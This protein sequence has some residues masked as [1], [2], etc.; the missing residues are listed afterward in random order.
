VGQR[1]NVG[2]GIWIK[3]DF[4]KVRK[5]YD[6]FGVL[7]ASVR[8]AAAWSNV[9]EHIAV[10]ENG[11]SRLRVKQDQRWISVSGAMGEHISML[12]KRGRN[13]RSCRVARAVARVVSGSVAAVARNTFVQGSINS[14]DFGASLRKGDATVVR[15]QNSGLCA[16]TSRFRIVLLSGTRRIKGGPV[17]L[18][19]GPC[20][21]GIGRIFIL[22]DGELVLQ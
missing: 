18:Q 6:K 17:R 19:H 15:K 13:R 1:Q 4:A 12:Q 8:D 3:P 5:I 22:A 10:S 11:D 2:D 20:R 16:N 14:C 7:I 21:C 9:P